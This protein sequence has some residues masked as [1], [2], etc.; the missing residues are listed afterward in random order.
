[1]IAHP[2][3]GAVSSKS[4]YRLT[5][6]FVGAAATLLMIPNLVHEPIILSVVITL[7]VSV[8]TFI[9]LLDRTPRSYAFMLSGYTVLLTGLPLVTA[10]LNTFDTVISRVEGITLAIVCASIISNI[11]L[12]VSVRPLLLGKIDI[13]LHSAQNL[14]K[15]TTSKS[16]EDHKHKIERHRLATDTNDLSLLIKHLS[17]EGSRYRILIQRI[18]HL[19]HKMATLPP[20]LDEL[21]DLRLALNNCGTART[22]KALHSITVFA[23]CPDIEPANNE[24]DRLC[25]SVTSY[26]TLVL[27]NLSRNLANIIKIKTECNL[28]RKTINDKKITRKVRGKKTSFD[29]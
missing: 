1:M 29:D 19:Q 27:S 13:W 24:Y 6:T 5:G 11:I 26:E 23:A 20:L 2:L 10:P 9:S 12:P 18:K 7:W 15:E 22:K 3:S 14:L 25:N 16:T 28:L 17:F 8:C 21:K 4:F